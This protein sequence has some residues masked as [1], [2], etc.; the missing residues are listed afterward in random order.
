MRPRRW[1]IALLLSLGLLAAGSLLL[2]HTLHVEQR[3]RDTLVQALQTA[4]MSGV[5]LGRVRPFVIGLELRDLELTLPG[6]NLRL[7]IDRVRL[8]ASLIHWL[9]NERE[10]ISAIRRVE[11]HGPSLQLALGDTKTIG[12]G[13]LGKSFSP[14]EGLSEAEAGRLE[15]LLA[16]LPEVYL[17]NGRIELAGPFVGDTS[18]LVLDELDGSLA[19]R[20]GQLYMLLQSRLL[21]GHRR[22]LHA[23]MVLKQAS[24][25]GEFNLQI[26]TLSLSAASLSAVPEGVRGELCCGMDIG[27]RITRGALD[28]LRGD[29]WMAV[30][31]LQLK[32]EF[33][34]SYHSPLALDLNGVHVDDGRLRWGE[35]EI[36]LQADTDLLL[37]EF[38]LCAES[39]DL[40]LRTVLQQAGRPEDLDGR[41]SL[42]AE[43]ERDTTGMHSTLKMSVADLS[44][45]GR[46]AGALQLRAHLQQEELVCDTLLW[47]NRHQQGEIPAGRLLANGQFQ[48]PW[49]AHGTV[50]KDR[51]RLQAEIALPHGESGGE[52]SLH[53]AGSIMS[54][55]PVLATLRREGVLD[56]L[57]A[58]I[59]VDLLRNASTVLSLHAN[60]SRSQGS[61]DLFDPSGGK[62]GSGNLQRQDSQWA[63][64][65]DVDSL[66]QFSSLAVLQDLP[67]LAE[68]SFKLHADGL[69]LEAEGALGIIGGQRDLRLQLHHTR[70]EKQSH[71]LATLVQRERLLDRRLGEVEFTVDGERLQCER[72]TLLEQLNGS[73]WVDLLNSSYLL[74][75]ECNDLD[76][77]NVMR[78]L[79]PAQLPGYSLGHLS[80]LLAGE[81]DLAHPGLR[82]GLEYRNRLGEAPF[83]LRGDI[84]VADTLLEVSRGGLSLV[85]HDLAELEL[86]H[87]PVENRGELKGS[88]TRIRLEE[89]YSAITTGRL[90][91]LGASESREKGVLAF[92]NWLPFLGRDEEGD[93][94]RSSNSPLRGNTQGELAMAWSKERGLELSLQAAADSLVL[95]G[96]RFSRANISLMRDTN[97]ADGVLRLDSLVVARSQPEFALHLAGELPYT[98]QGELDLVLEMQGD[99]LEPLTVTSEGGRSS[100]WRKASGP[101][102]VH[103]EVGGSYTEPQLRSGRVW[104]HEGYAEMKYIF[105]SLDHVNIEMEVANNQLT[106][107]K[108][109]A[110]VP[111]GY[112]RIRNLP[113]TVVDG[114][115][116]EPWVIPGIELDLGVLTWETLDRRG[117]PGS[118]EL[119]LPGF[120]EDDWDAKV[121][122]R[123]L[124][125]GELTYVAGPME[126]PRLIGRLEVHSGEFT[127]PPIK[128]GGPPD[129]ITTWILAALEAAQWDVE[130]VVGRNLNYTYTHQ[131]FET[132]PVFNRLKTVLDRVAVDLSID[133]SN[134]PVHIRGR[135]LDGDFHLLGRMTSTE[136]TI[137]AIGRQFRIEQAGMEFDASS[138][139]PVVWGRAA[140]YGVE[141]T[142]ESIFQQG[143]Q[144]YDAG[145]MFLELAGR[146]E[147]GSRVTRVRWDEAVLE[148]V[149]SE[150]NTANDNLENEQDLLSEFGYG[151]DQFSAEE[152]IPGMV[153]GFI[154]L[155][156]GNVESRLR[157][158]LGLDLVK[159]YVPLV[160]NAVEGL[161][162]D[163]RQ[164][165]LSQ[166]YLSYLQ[167]SRLV[168]GKSIGPRYFAT[169]TGQ[170]T[171]APSVESDEVN[172]YQRFSLE[173][174][175]NYNLTLTGEL[176]FDPWR[177]GGV[178]TG[179]PRMLLRYRLYY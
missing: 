45:Q 40:P 15:Q 165:L 86:K 97:T 105:R 146:D 127:Y 145:Q 122:L 175:V 167:G 56:S 136:G 62:R 36:H 174:N 82:G 159:I 17:R 27:G 151:A 47:V 118:V 26:D 22:G 134:D 21:D 94:D 126:E 10:P 156:L 9:R 31:S 137:N 170:L 70:V 166:S 169:W 67:L 58:Q 100:F 24:L 79:A 3:L 52:S 13:N 138:M 155:P 161:F 76:L 130:L 103:V 25:S 123:G 16:L 8:R 106:I 143:T 95:A 65:L 179:D 163:T 2:W 33:V 91:S 48:L 150:G 153:A 39:Q 29:G 148:L 129:A 38:N 77:D 158:E 42:S 60:G 172:L 85:G 73:G 68:R 83:V 99:L 120:M 43:L 112:A 14:E 154:D 74:D 144:S 7:H 50:V 109:D 18:R 168:L 35:Q 30:D 4:G 54:P 53:F 41:I 78:A 89:L 71:F 160:R 49:G 128:S 19:M 90:D 20:E 69:D 55:L 1:V 164:S 110:Q 104:I 124:R 111:G 92:L 133:P 117:H 115:E 34:L 121:L 147:M 88:L 66:Q 152:M 32:P 59:T 72:V 63:W 178:Y 139:L 107:Q 23:S 116:L 81:G 131:G 11:L 37:R 51:M 125:P 113:G 132:L 114:V 61:F 171:T 93:I 64:S 177:H 12:T 142:E 149:D 176:V 102:G 84:I 173:Y 162:V 75:I 5:E 135:M 98:D 119:V 80:L 101:G 46:A 57:Q 87:N 157:R 96:R 141:D 108:F 44:V 140:Y 6:E 28:S